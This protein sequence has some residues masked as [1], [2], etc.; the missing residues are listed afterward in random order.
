MRGAVPQ[1]QVHDQDRHAWVGLLQTYGWPVSQI[2]TD[3]PATHDQTHAVALSAECYRLRL[4]AIAE[5]FGRPLTP[6]EQGAVIKWWATGEQLALV[7]RHRDR[8]LSAWC[9]NHTRAWVWPAL[10]DPWQ[11]EPGDEVIWMTGE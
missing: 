9:R 5:D 4:D 10:P 7:V 3:S 6:D 11:P 8:Y 1:G 2:R